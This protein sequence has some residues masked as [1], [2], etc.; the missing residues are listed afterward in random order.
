MLDS[1]YE[2][3]V[4]VGSRK[5]ARNAQK[6]TKVEKKKVCSLKQVESLEEVKVVPLSKRKCKK[7]S[8]S[9]IVKNEK[10]EEE[11]GTYFFNL[12]FFESF[13]LFSEI[14]RNFFSFC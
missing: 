5:S 3:T 13:S 2:V 7:S 9:R 1:D 10:K 14:L 6:Q 11:T 8:V 12:I 4:N